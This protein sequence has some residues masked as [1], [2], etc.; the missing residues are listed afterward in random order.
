MT[1]S[2]RTSTALLLTVALH[3]ALLAALLARN[4]VRIP[5]SAAAQ[6]RPAIA[7]IFSAPRTAAVPPLPPLRPDRAPPAHR[8]RPAAAQAI[9][10]SSAERRVER[11]SAPQPISTAGNSARQA[12]PPS[13]A[14]QRSVT[15]ATIGELPAQQAQAASGTAARSV[16]EPAIGDLSAQPAQ[17]PVSAAELLRLTVHG[18]GKIDQELRGGKLA[19]LPPPG[20]TLRGKIDAAFEAAHEAVRPKWYERAKV[21]EITSPNSRI[22]VYKIRTALGTY[23]I[24]MAD[25]SMNGGGYSS[26]SYSNC[27]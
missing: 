1:H 19:P 6:G 21:T 27:P 11:A 7:W 20:Q 17:P 23:C 12:Q 8:E 22:R 14:A 16:A 10:A 13:D 24:S 2:S 3:L 25:A 9:T 15:E 4:H 26:P 18:A 5:A